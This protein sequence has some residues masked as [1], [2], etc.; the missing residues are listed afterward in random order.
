[1]TAPPPLSADVV[2]FLDAHIFTLA[3]LEVLLV[4]HASGGTSRP[5]EELA[6]E[7]YV[8]AAS[9]RPWL[10]DFVADGLLST[11]GAGAYVART[12]DVGVQATLDQ[13]ADTYSRRKVSVARH[14]YST[15]EDP[16]VRLAEAFRFRK[17]KPQ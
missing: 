12:D 10:E 8:P 17:D 3:Q 11:D 5:I 14:V 4:V 6:R 1:M 2:A 13:V 16:A 15:K 9:L 7:L